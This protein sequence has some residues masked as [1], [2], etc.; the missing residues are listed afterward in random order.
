MLH[1]PGLRSI[2]SCEI[3]I[4]LGRNLSSGLCHRSKNSIVH[5]RNARLILLWGVIGSDFD[6]GQ[7]NTG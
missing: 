7:D 1:R 2:G 5:W 6:L 3:R 4:F